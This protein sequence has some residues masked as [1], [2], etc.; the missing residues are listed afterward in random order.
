M[1][2]IMRKAKKQE[3]TEKTL[4]ENIVMVVQ[5]ALTSFAFMFFPL[6][7]YSFAFLD[8][9]STGGY[10]SLAFAILLLVSQSVGRFFV[11]WPIAILSYLCVIILPGLMSFISG[12]GA[13]LVSF[14][15][16]AIVCVIGFPFTD[17]MVLWSSFFYSDTYPKGRLKFS[18]IVSIAI[19]AGSAVCGFIFF[20]MLAF[21]LSRG[22]SAV[23]S[24]FWFAW[25]LAP[26]FQL[27][28][29]VSPL[30]NIIS[31]RCDDSQGNTGKD[32]GDKDGKGKADEEDS[33]N[34]DKHKANEEGAG[35]EETSA[36]TI[37]EDSGSVSGSEDKE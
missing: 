36:L 6:I 9:S 1:I 12:F 7:C 4:L 37:S 35:S 22:A 24:L 17:T 21:S 8:G 16:L 2:D 32:S 13:P 26:W 34:D 33:G 10:A 15:V 27:I 11:K 29:L 20:V 31:S 19:R 18:L 5:A 28:V 30:P 14:L 23:A 25:I 3:A